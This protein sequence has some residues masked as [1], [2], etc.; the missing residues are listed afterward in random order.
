MVTRFCILKHGHQTPICYRLRC[1][2]TLLYL[3]A[4]IETNVC[5][6]IK[7]VSNELMLLQIEFN[8][9]QFMFGA[10]LK[11]GKFPAPIHLGENRVVL[12]DDE[13]DAWLYPNVENGM[14]GVLQG[15]F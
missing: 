4:Y 7:C 1:L 15:S 6:A 10:W 9:T 13:V 11:A 14:R 2:G 3:S 5:G 12:A 8:T